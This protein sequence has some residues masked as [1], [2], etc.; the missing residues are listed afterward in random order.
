MQEKKPKILIRDRIKYRFD[1]FISSGPKSIFLM[2]LVMFIIA[3]LL[4]ALM[5]A[6][7]EY[8]ILKSGTSENIIND[9]WL[10]FLQI[11]DAGA[12][13]EDTD[14]SMPMKIVGIVT[15]LLGMIFF[16]GVIAFITTELDKKMSD[17]RKGRSAVLEKGHIV[18][19]G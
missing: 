5:R 3:F 8:F 6:G 16:S 12:V 4:T 2:L 9:I 17:L 14:N 1:N 11:T 10:S 7:V 19:L 15:I 18:V 13:A